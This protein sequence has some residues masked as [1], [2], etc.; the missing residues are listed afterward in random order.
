MSTPAHADSPA[1]PVLSSFKQSLDQT[2]VIAPTLPAIANTHAKPTTTA[3]ITAAKTSQAPILDENHITV[4]YNVQVEHLSKVTLKETAAGASAQSRSSSHAPAPSAAA[5]SFTGKANPMAS[6]KEPLNTL[7]SELALL[8][9]KSASNPAT[10]T[11]TDVNR[12]HS[13]NHAATHEAAPASSA[14]NSSLIDTPIHTSSSSGAVNLPSPGSSSLV[15]FEELFVA[16]H[17]EEAERELQSISSSLYRLNVEGLT[18]LDLDT[19]DQIDEI[20]S[21]IA[22]LLLPQALARKTSASAPASGAG[23]FGGLGGDDEW[24]DIIGGEDGIDD[25]WEDESFGVHDRAGAATSGVS[26]KAVSVGEAP[27]STSQHLGMFEEVWNRGH[28][29]ISAA[30][31]AMRLFAETHA[32]AHTAA[33]KAVK[34]ANQY[35]VSSCL[36]AS[37]CFHAP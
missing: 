22:S 1:I 37:H 13:T 3:V 2:K 8:S 21:D 32:H 23:A 26:D 25:G 11:V 15:T 31:A 36:C 20:C 34:S 14:N 9:S 33:T 29:H 17:G 24:E 27:V 28:K 35:S 5:G 10:D 12:A 7:A 16:K 19:R 6:T 30:Q 4:D 18:K